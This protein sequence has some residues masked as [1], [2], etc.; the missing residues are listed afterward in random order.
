MADN[1]SNVSAD[2]SLLTA[3][4]VYSE[5]IFV[6]YDLIDLMVDKL[7][8]EKLLWF[9]INDSILDDSDSMIPP[10]CPYNNHSTF[11]IIS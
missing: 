7:F 4:G 3:F 8:A 10:R 9:I 5:R 11:T 1:A 2:A 6:T